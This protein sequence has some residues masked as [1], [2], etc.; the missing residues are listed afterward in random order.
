MSYTIRIKDVTS[1]RIILARRRCSGAEWGAVLEDLLRGV[2]TRLNQLESV[3]VGPAMARIRELGGAALEVEAGFPIVEPVQIEAPFEVGQL[4]PGR[5][6]T[7]LHEGP[8]ERLF[9]AA[10]ALDEWV[11]VEKLAVEAAPWFIF[12]VDPDE[13]E[14]PAALRTELVLPLLA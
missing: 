6:A 11:A 1:Q 12:W 9:D 10:A 14:T 2:W 8:Y 5:A 7:T 13:A 4:A 3:T